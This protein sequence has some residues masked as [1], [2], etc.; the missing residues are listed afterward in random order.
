MVADKYEV[1]IS[2]ECWKWV[3]E[4]LTFKNQVLTWLVTDKYEVFI[5]LDNNY[6]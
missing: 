6:K 2:L 1:F 4:L 3:Y 5:N